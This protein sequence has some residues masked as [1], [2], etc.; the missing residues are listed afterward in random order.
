MTG[1]R[2]DMCLPFHYGFSPEGCKL[3]DCDPSG[4]TDMQCDLISGQC[5]CRDKVEGRKCDRCMENTRSKDTGGFG[6]KICEPCDDC[7][8]LVQ[9]AAD[10]HRQSLENLDALLQKIAENP[11]PVGNDFEYEMTAL[12]VKVKSLLADTKLA[13]RSEDGDT[14]RDRLQNLR[15][16]LQDV[17]DLI[18]DAD[19]NIMVAKDQGQEVKRDVSRV[20]VVIQEARTALKVCN[21]KFS[22]PPY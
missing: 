12:N 11:E 7:Y 9:D 13:S 20:K 14:L 8:N 21:N 22:P 19:G 5:P 2:C 3:C 1:Q 18:V 10:E 16:R 4:S 15:T 17:V 6:E